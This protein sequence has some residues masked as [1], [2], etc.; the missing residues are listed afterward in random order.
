[1]RALRGVNPLGER[2]GAGGVGGG[3]DGMA[4]YAFGN[5]MAMNY[6]KAEGSTR[7]RAGSAHI[8][9]IADDDQP[10]AR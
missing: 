5:L 7:L 1:M 3:L 6:R 9:C 10:T 8:P 2:E 4:I